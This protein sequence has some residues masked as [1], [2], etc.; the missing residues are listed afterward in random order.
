MWLTDIMDRVSSATR[1]R[2]MSE[3]RGKNT[4]PELL[5]RKIL[6]SKG[7][8]FRLHRKDLIGTPDIFLP[9]LNTVIFVHGC[10]WH[11]HEKCRFSKIPAS[12]RE[13]WEKKLVGNHQR[14]QKNIRSLNENG[15]RVLIVWECVIRGGTMREHL[16]HDLVFWLSGKSWFGEL[17]SIPS[18]PNFFQRS[19]TLL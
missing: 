3:I 17:S 14:D 7:Y 11:L 15:F 8:R 2:M 1:S 6:F 16:D 13:F 10:F 12:N 9:K 18:D 19:D 5:V 4:A